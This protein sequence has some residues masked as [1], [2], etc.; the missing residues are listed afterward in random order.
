MRI[1]VI[2][3]YAQYLLP[4]ADIAYTSAETVETLI[5]MQDWASDPN[6]NNAFR[7]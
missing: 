6:I 3:D 7:K 2:V 1:A 4:R 5:R